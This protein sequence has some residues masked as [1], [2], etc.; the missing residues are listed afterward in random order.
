M[1]AGPAELV[2]A[3]NLEI[4]HYLLDKTLFIHFDHFM[5]KLQSAGEVTQKLQKDTQKY[6][7][8]KN[9]AYGKHYQYWTIS[10]VSKTHCPYRVELELTGASKNIFIQI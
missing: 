1:I 3:V 10:L 4:I 8:I 2:H 9:I 7:S 6:C 5:D